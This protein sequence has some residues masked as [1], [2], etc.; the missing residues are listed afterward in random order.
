M[1]IIFSYGKRKMLWWL[2]APIAT[3]E[4]ITITQNPVVRP[5]DQKVY[6]VSRM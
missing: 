6:C 3:Q 5:G 1:E 2:Q 4:N